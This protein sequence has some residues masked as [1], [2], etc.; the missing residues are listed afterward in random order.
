MSDDFGDDDFDD[1]FF[2]EV[3]DI[4]AVAVLTAAAPGPTKAI[5]RTTSHPGTSFNKGWTGPQRS[6]SSAS[7]TSFRPAQKPPQLAFQRPA[8][9]SKASPSNSTGALLSPRAKGAE[10]RRLALLGL[11]AQPAPQAQS[12]GL[13]F[14]TVPRPVTASSSRAPSAH[15]PSAQSSFSRLGRTSSGPTGVQTHLS[16]RK[17]NQTTKGKVWDRTAFAATGRKRVSKNKEALDAQKKRKRGEAYDDDDDDMGE[18]EDDWGEPL[19]P[20]PKSKVD[21]CKS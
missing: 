18:E 20:N 2:R 3:D 12:Q 6:V 15:V 13:G 14:K 7:T 21:L 8:V 17:E 9:Q 16:F 10:A 1:S 11:S 4:A 19:A 5:P